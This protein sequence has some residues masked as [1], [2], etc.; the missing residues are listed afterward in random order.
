[1]NRVEELFNTVK[2]NELIRKQKRNKSDVWCKVLCILAAV[3]AV[4][5]IAYCVYRFMNPRSKCLDDFE[6]AFEDELDDDFFE[7]E[8][9]EKIEIE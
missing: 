8:L 3:I 6:E 9:A 1:M 4:A 2:L 7:D 5:A